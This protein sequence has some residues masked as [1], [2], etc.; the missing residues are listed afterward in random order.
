MVYLILICK[1]LQYGQP[2]NTDYVPWLSFTNQAEAPKF[3]EINLNNDLNIS[4][5]EIFLT[6]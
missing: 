3:G 4:H 6:S 5:N 2:F 1:T